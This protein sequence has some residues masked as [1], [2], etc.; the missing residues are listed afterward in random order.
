VLPVEPTFRLER[1]F[2]ERLK[3]RP[4]PWGFP[5]LSEVVYYRTYSRIKDDGQQETWAD[6]VVRVVEGVFSIRKHWNRLMGLAWD[7]RAMQEYAQAMA[8]H[9]F[10]M[11]FLPPGRG[12]WAMGTQ[13]VYERGSMALNN[14]AFV[15]VTFS[16][17]DA[18]AWL[19]D[20]LMLGVG[21]GFD[22]HRY[23]AQRPLSAPGQTGQEVFV[24][25]DSREGWVESVAKLIRS[26]EELGRPFVQFDYSQIRPAGSPIRGFGGIASGPEPLKR[27]HEQLRSFLDRYVGKV[28]DSRLIADV[29]NAIGCC[30]VAGNVRRSAEICLGSPY[31]PVFLN[32]KNYELYPDRAEIGWMS[33]NSVVLAETNDFERIPDIAEGIR[34]NGEPGILNLKNVRKYGRFGE[35]RPDE[36]IGVNPCGEIPLESYELCNLAEVFPTR[37]RSESD[38]FDTLDFATFYSSTVSLLMSHSPQ[39]N[40]VLSRNRR[41]G[42]SVS[43]VADWIDAVGA[44]KVFS[45]LNR[46]YDFVRAC[47]R[48]LAM[49]AG[50][51]ESVRVTTVKPSGTISLLAGVSPG[52]HHPEAGYVLRRIRIAEHSPIAE[53][54]VRAGVPHE[55]DVYSSKTLVF[56]FPLAYGSGRTR[57]VRDVSVWEQ[58]AIVAML[59][60][61]WADNAVSNT[62]KFQPHEANQIE[63]VLT[64][65]TPQVKSLSMLPDVDEGV[66][67]QMPV[68]RITKAK[69]RELMARIES[70][71]WSGILGD[72]AGSRFCDGES[73]E[74]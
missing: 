36:A 34:R 51:P 57:S 11:K 9:M 7:E 33:N 43:G 28:P 42:V 64:F 67:P 61:C 52:M 23:V 56:E 20:A 60:R 44:S 55:P 47:N 35:E 30:V 6:T 49:R 72:G 40:E 50:V 37:C 39:T 41:I 26:Y 66:Y 32:L 8:E 38:L 63:R 19:M 10:E 24:I 21:V 58:A 46:A 68:E 15:S 18:A 14:C 27:L 2:V 62:L 3:Q 69:F 12:L 54:L 29:M 1:E 22:T 4:V 65:F 48:T 25:P 45:I 71:E 70:I 5:V 31:D 73:C 74:L 13:T 53:R 59:Q 17:A 16:L